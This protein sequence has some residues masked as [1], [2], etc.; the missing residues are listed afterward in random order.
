M[1]QINGQGFRTVG[2][3]FSSRVKAELS[4]LKVPG[5]C[6]ARAELASLVQTLGSLVIEGGGRVRLELV[7]E[8]P[9][10]AR[11]A[12]SLGK[13][14]YGWR[15]RILTRRRSR[16]KKNRV[17]MVVVPFDMDV[18]S[19]LSDMGFS[20]PGSLPSGRA[21]D[22]LVD[23]PCCQAAYLRGHFLGGGSILSPERGY[24]LS[25]AMGNEG[26]QKHLREILRSLDIAASS[27]THRRRPVL[28]VKEGESVARFL[29]LVGAHQSLLQFEG[30]RVVRDMRNLANRRVNADTA[31][32]EKA[33]RAGLRQAR[34]VSALD[35]A[36]LMAKL[37][38][39]WQELARLRARHPEV[40][41]RE[42]GDMLN[43]PLSKSTVQGRLRRM[44]DL[45]A[46]AGEGNGEN[47]RGVWG[48]SLD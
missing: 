21:G 2:D 38:P 16:L 9:G 19:G 32:V 30:K 11:R 48:N 13:M 40:S 45:A 5:A 15:G 42:L 14:A 12:F 10:T 4:S 25:L 26:R 41:L 28:Y 7:T 47:P 31:N 22:D 34:A 35:R 33:V 20:G 44:E 36:G 18:R 17:Y 1:A 29:Q 24:H 3:S 8:H 39:D 37:P 23:R 6:C 46:K 43:P 27:G